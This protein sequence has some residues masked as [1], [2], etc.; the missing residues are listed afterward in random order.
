MDSAAVK[1]KASW[2]SFSIVPLTKNGKDKKE[3]KKKKKKCFDTSKEKTATIL[4]QSKTAYLPSH[5][6][7][8]TYWTLQGMS[9][10][11]THHMDTSAP[12]LEHNP[13]RELQ[14]IQITFHSH[15]KISMHVPNH[16]LIFTKFCSLQRCQDKIKFTGN[17]FPT[18]SSPSTQSANCAS[19]LEPYFRSYQV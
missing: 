6:K 12:M 1:Q 5:R 15:P 18:K 14:I 7:H 8:I 16:E 3:W 11:P 4:F 10:T 19:S 9:Q 17:K 13:G 2:C